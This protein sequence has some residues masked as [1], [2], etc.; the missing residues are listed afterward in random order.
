MINKN[1][2]IIRTGILFLF[3][4]A[5]LGPWAYDLINVPAQYTCQPPNVRLYGDFCGVPLSGAFIFLLIPSFFHSVWE[6]LTST[7]PYYGR[8]S[9]GLSI[10]LLFPIFTTIFSLW[11]KETHRLRMMNLIAWILAFL[12]TLTLFILQINRQA[13]HLWGLWFYILAATGAIIFEVS[14]QLG[15]K[16]SVNKV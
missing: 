11:R 1:R 6:L 7:L 13:I 14:A 10:L 9:S 8:L 3:I 5:M 2:R 15:E 4:I 16:R 12:L